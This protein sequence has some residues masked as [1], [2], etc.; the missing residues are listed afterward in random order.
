MKLLASLLGL[1]KRNEAKTL[2]EYQREILVKAGR[3]QFKKLHELG[4]TIP[5]SLV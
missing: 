5:V 4:L 1:N 2:A 3:Q